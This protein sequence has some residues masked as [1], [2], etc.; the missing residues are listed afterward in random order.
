MNELRIDNNINSATSNTDPASSSPFLLSSKSVNTNLTAAAAAASILSKLATRL[1]SPAEHEQLDHSHDDENNESSHNEEDDQCDENNNR[2][3][4]KSE[5]VENENRPE[6]DYHDDDQAS[7]S[8]PDE[9]NANNDFQESFIKT[10]HNT[11]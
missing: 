3:T 2:I 4:V 11:G 7:Y 1:K 9:D 10:E 6:L 8:D 5:L